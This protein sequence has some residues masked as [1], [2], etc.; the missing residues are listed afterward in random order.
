MASGSTTTRLKL[1]DS[2]G[3]TVNS[4][5][6]NSKWK[7]YSGYPIRVHSKDYTFDEEV[8]MQGLDP[9][10]DNAILLDTALSGL[11]LDGYIVD[12]PKYPTS[13]DPTVNS[14]YKNIYVYQ[15]NQ[16]PIVSGISQTQFTIDNAN[17]PDVAVGYLVFIHSND[18]ALE[19]ETTIITDI[20]GTT[21]TVNKPLGFTPS[22]DQKIE[23]LGF[24]DQ[25]RPYIIL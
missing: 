22:L 4:Y 14:I 25:G 17:L 3:T 5:S 12:I 23:L 9:S 16:V 1:L 15:T 19:S 2:F 6:E 21:I 10:D 11:P 7:N 13:S 24:F 18:F 20:T 8:I